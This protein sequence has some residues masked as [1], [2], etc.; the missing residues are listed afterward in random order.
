MEKAVNLT[1]EQAISCLCDEDTVHVFTD[2]GFI[3]VGADWAKNEVVE[4]LQ[5][6]GYIQIGGSV[7]RAMGHGIVVFPKGAKV[8]SELL[9]VQCDDK[10]L[11][12]FDTNKK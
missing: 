5:S 3:L 6:A 2:T 9:F 1:A 10:K 4:L 12:Q 11:S 8:H 7:C